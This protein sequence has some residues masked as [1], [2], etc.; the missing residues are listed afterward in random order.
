MTREAEIQAAF[1][2]WE[3]WKVK[4]AKSDKSLS[5]ADC[6]DTAQAWVRFQ[7]LYLG[8]NSKLAKMPVVA[9]N[10]L[11]FLRRHDVGGAA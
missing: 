4:K 2:A 6:H 10:V 5:F 1:D 8:D 11:P 9:A 7:N 3:D